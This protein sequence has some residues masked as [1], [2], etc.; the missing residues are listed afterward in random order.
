MSMSVHKI[1]TGMC[2]IC[3][4]DFYETKGDLKFKSQF[5]IFSR[6]DQEEPLEI[7]PLYQVAGIYLF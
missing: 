3:E 6:A 4:A 2:N 1:L 5:R 7:R